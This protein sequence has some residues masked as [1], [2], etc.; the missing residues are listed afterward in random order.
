MKP[1][2]STDNE[3]LSSDP[4]ILDQGRESGGTLF[5]QPD[6]VHCRRAIQVSDGAQQPDPPESAI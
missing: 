2:P 1:A 4:G 6:Q 5:R 3:T